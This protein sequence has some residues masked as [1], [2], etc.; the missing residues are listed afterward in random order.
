MEEV[1]IGVFICH[2]GLN[3]AKSVDVKALREYASKLPRVVHAVDYE[4]MCSETGQKMIKDAIKEK[5]LNRIVVASC[6]PKLH[7]LTFRRAVKEAGLNPFL[8]EMANIR[9]HCS[10]PHMHEPEKATEKAKHIL[11]SSIERCRYLEEIG[12]KEEAVKPSALIVGGGIAGIQAALSLAD[13]GFDVY[14]VERTPWLGGKAAQLGRVFPTED[15]GI[16]LSPLANETHRKCL[17]K[18]R[19]MNHPRIN[20]YTSS[21]VKA[22]SGY[23]G[24]F[25][26]RI[27]RKPRFVDEEL[28]VACGECE[29]VCP[30][31][32]PNE[33]D[34]GLSKRKAIYKPFAQALPHAYSIDI[35]HCTK[36]G[37]CVKVCPT[38]AINLN[39]IPERVEVDVGTVIVA[40]GFDEYEPNGLLGYGTY[41]NVITQFQLARLLD[42]SGPTG[43]RL[44]RPS[45]SKR[46]RRIV[47]VQCVGSRDPEVNPYCS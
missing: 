30:V 42:P 47:M 25:K 3:I 21:T 35:E 40:A 32:V 1:R 6:S 43:G 23:I 11:R 29:K 4:F 38:D 26:A 34:L 15:C 2:C 46:P 18:E 24:N 31:E 41:P 7:E 20:V 16:C 14:L 19:I 9:E 17:Y 28:C 8:F 22:L 37:E 33:V 10:W 39:G 13:Y 12:E 36:C 27:E 5:N 44:E 45:D